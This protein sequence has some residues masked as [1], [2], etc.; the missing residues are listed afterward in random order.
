MPKPRFFLTLALILMLVG[1][2]CAGANIYFGMNGHSSLAKMFFIFGALI[3][4][5]G[6]IATVLWMYCD[7]WFREPQ[8]QQGKPKVSFGPPGGPPGAPPPGT[9]V[10]RMPP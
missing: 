3:I 8:Q 9:P 6:G 2:S 5:A 1:F 10:K 7:A 4:S